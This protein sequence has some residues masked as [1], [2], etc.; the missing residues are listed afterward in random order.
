[1][2]KV[3]NTAFSTPSTRPSK[4][5]NRKQQKFPWLSLKIDTLKILLMPIHFVPVA[6]SLF[7]V[8]QVFYYI[9]HSRKRRSFLF[10]ANVSQ[11][12]K[13]FILLS[14]ILNKLSF[15][16]LL[17]SIKSDRQLLEEKSFT[18]RLKCF[19]LLEERVLLNYGRN[20]NRLGHTLPGISKQMQKQ[21]ALAPTQ[22]PFHFPILNFL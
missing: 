22:Q 13:G 20:L 5:R 6:V 12:R 17:F 15:S 19:I 3:D 11:S 21:I 16:P 2:N 7:P 8:N 18:S 10:T 9:G 14:V 1:M 4:R